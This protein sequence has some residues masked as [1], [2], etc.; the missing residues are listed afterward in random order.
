[1]LILGND[2][3][4]AGLVRE[5]AVARTCVGT[6]TTVLVALCH[7]EVLDAAYCVEGYEIAQNYTQELNR[8]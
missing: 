8:S 3:Y 4:A 6:G 5:L 1:M 2:G 7:P